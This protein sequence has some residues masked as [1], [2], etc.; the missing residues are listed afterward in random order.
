[1]VDFAAYSEAIARLLTELDL[2]PVL[3]DVGA[4]GAP[5]SLWKPISSRSVYVGFDPDLRQMQELSKGQFYKSFV[6]NKA[7]SPQDSLG[8]M[9]FFLTRSPSCSS[10][11]LPDKE[12]LSEYLF[13]EL[14]EVEQEVTVQ[15]TT[16]NETLKRLF[17]AGIDWL[18]LDS[19]GIDLRLFLSLSSDVRSR[20]VTLDIEPGIIDAYHNEDLFIDSHRELISDGFWL[21]Y[22]R[23]GEAVRGRW[24]TLD[25]LSGFSTKTERKRF[26]ASIRPSPAW[27]EARYMRTVEWLRSTGR[28]ERMFALLWIFAILD[29]QYGFGLDV[30]RECEDTFGA[31]TVSSIMKSA[32]LKSTRHSSTSVIRAAKSVVPVSVR[33]TLKNAIRA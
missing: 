10:T 29:G 21:S 15:A 17:L 13:S 18:K 2:H 7:V 30:A 27:V 11:L 28:S 5:P 6:I 14:F 25:W 31:G 19:Q 1:L 12:A 9:P 26:E 3:V 24:E 20:V 32:A 33:Q 4:S 23:V 16:L 8:E 22:I